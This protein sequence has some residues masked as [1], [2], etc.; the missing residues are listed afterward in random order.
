VK[1]RPAQATLNDLNNGH[2]MVRLAEAIHEAVAA[3]KIHGKPAVVTL[4]ITV[5]TMKGQHNLVN[6]PVV[7]SGEISS[8]LPKAPPPLTLFFVDE[9][10]NPTRNQTREPELPL[11]ITSINK[12]TGEINGYE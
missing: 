8:K 10:G 5:A 2:V 3:V 1:I 6:P 11:N 9:D 12:Q 7:I 4:D